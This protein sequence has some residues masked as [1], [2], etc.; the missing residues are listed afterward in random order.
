MIKT[1]YIP[2]E[3]G[4]IREEYR[5]GRGVFG[6]H[7]GLMRS[8]DSLSE[9]NRNLLILYADL[10][11]CAKVAKVYNCNRHTIWKRVR[12]IREILKTKL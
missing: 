1:D 9:D 5:M 10:G 8:L 7:P 11:S 3:F 2:E 4:N 6:N 12:R